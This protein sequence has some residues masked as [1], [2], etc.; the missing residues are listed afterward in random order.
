MP[1]D[2]APSLETA[3]AEFSDAWVAGEPLDPDDFCR[4]YP[5]FFPDL[6]RRI[7]E[8][9]YVVDGLDSA[10]G[11]MGDGGPETIPLAAGPSAD[12]VLGDFRI[13]R[14]IGRGGMGLVYEAEQVSLHRAVALKVLPPHLSFSDE[15]VLKFRR[16][17]E[18]GGRQSHP[19][20]VSVYAVGE[21]NGLHYIAQELVP[22]SRTL[23]DRLAELRG[24]GDLPVGYFRRSA[25]VLIA[26]AEA[27]GHAHDSG[28]IHRDVKPSNILLAGDDSPKLTDFGLAR[29]E[30]ALA[31]SRTGD[32]VGTPY[33]M[34]PEQVGGRKNIDF[35]TD[36]FSLGVT[37]YEML[38]LSL[39]FEGDTSQEVLRKILSHEPRDPRRL[40]H[41]VPRDLAVI[42][43]KA[44]EKR[45]DSRY[46]T[47][48]ELAD[49]L[50]RYVNGEPILARPAGAVTR[51]VKRIRRNPATSLAVGALFALLIALLTAVWL[52]GARKQAEEAE[53]EALRKKEGFRLAAE[54][55]IRVGQNAGQAVLLAIEA[56]KR[57]SAFV[58]RMVLIEAIRAC[59]VRKVI[60]HDGAVTAV[61]VRPGGAE[62]VTA[63]SLHSVQIWDI[64]KGEVLHNLVGHS[65]KVN[66][67]AYS[68]DGAF[69]LSASDDGTVRIWNASTG[70]EIH[71][72]AGHGDAVLSAAFS[73]DGRHV[74][75]ASRDM[76][77]MIW[78]RKSGERIATHEGY[79]WWVTA[80]VFLPDGKSVL[81]GSMDGTVRIR[82][83]AGKEDL[84]LDDRRSAV[85]SLSL[86]ADGSL[87][88][89]ASPDGEPRIY[90]VGAT[91]SLL[92][93]KHYAA[94]T[95]AAL[96]PDGMVAVTVSEDGNV[97]IWNAGTGEKLAILAGH[98]GSVGTLS[99]DAGSGTILTGSTDGTARVWDRHP[100][101]GTFLL[102]G[103]EGW[104][105]IALSSDGRRAARL[106]RDGMVFEIVDCESGAV[107]SCLDQEKPARRHADFSEDGECLLTA[108]SYNFPSLRRVSDGAELLLDGSRHEGDADQIEFLPG[109]EN[110]FLVGGGPYV[111]IRALPSGEIKVRI[112]L[113]NDICYA[114]ISGDGKRVLVLDVKGIVTVWDVSGVA[115]AEIL[116]ME[117]K[118]FSC[119]DLSRDGEKVAAVTAEG[120][121][122]LFDL[123]RQ[124]IPG[125]W[126]KLPAGVD[127]VRFSPD[128]RKIV[129][130]GCDNEAI[131]FTL[132]SGE[133]VARCRHNN[134]C[135]AVL[136]SPDGKHL[137]TREDKWNVILRNAENMEA[138]FPLPHREPVDRC[139]FCS[140]GSRVVTSTIDGS[141]SIWPVD[142][143]EFAKDG[144]S[145]DFILD[146]MEQF[147]LWDEV[148]QKVLADVESKFEN[149]ITTEAVKIA[150]K[151]EQKTEEERRAAFRVVSK[152]RDRPELLDR[153]SRDLLERPGAGGKEYERAL[154]LAEAVCRLAPGEE[155]Y[156]RT[157]GNALFRTGNFERS[158]ENLAPLGRTGEPDP[159]VSAMI[160]MALHHLG[161]PEE[162][163]I[164]LEKL[165]ILMTDARFAEDKRAVA[166][167]RE[168]EM[169]IGRPAAD[170]GVVPFRAVEFDG[171]SIEPFYYVCRESEGQWVLKLFEPAK[172][173]DSC[174]SLSLLPGEISNIAF[175][176]TDG[177]IC[178]FT[179]VGKCY[180]FVVQ[181][182]DEGGKTGGTGARILFETDEGSAGFIEW[183]PREPIAYFSMHEKLV[184][185]SGSAICSIDT[186][187]G[188]DHRPRR[189]LGCPGQVFEYFSVSPDGKRA[190]FSY[191][192][193]NSKGFETEVWSVS[194]CGAGR[195]V[196]DPRRLTCDG[197]ADDFKLHCRESGAIYWINRIRNIS[198]RISSMA[199]D[200]TGKRTVVDSESFL[201][202]RP[203]PFSLSAS[204][205][206]AYSIHQD[207]WYSVV[208]VDPDRRRFGIVLSSDVPI[209]F[210]RFVTGE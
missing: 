6:R 158:L 40:S 12:T 108:S 169:T 150:L 50:G 89:T 53:Q 196:R 163:G 70:E 118:R 49:D 113:E 127:F 137:I 75:T 160:A 138:L 189:I 54:A 42:C 110:F 157:L 60:V 174:F 17:A 38:T 104:E 148:E 202:L 123:G 176:P 69:L 201:L 198:T 167:L 120:V 161:R 159:P 46:A 210:P 34:S 59:H 64:R 114:R 27:L 84:W 74:A 179:I 204:G 182:L 14:E 57:D 107:L 143:V 4:N 125:K 136:F 165:R 152:Y 109:N 183:H 13:L 177:T 56:V 68:S 187:E 48:A 135:G 131:L 67:L 5:E 24:L 121:V 80:V 44:M 170:E 103:G 85:S 188:A 105:N 166:C 112:P 21:E 25:K 98:E 97:R 45:P 81:S 144:K 19:G 146:E 102:S 115:P 195:S 63:S 61:A 171:E 181:E 206:I 43:L 122:A 15:A 71:V 141:L 100:G 95:Q 10:A 124:R 154:D 209:L 119:A 1:V 58:T 129:L 47:M 184:N 130:A 149:L 191:F 88:I 91:K 203:G 111:N 51:V 134:A 90:K 33:Y 192:P 185:P 190:C 155:R 76:T 79:G 83:I 30:D 145:R 168:A 9:L 11:K 205:L 72:L 16:E 194:V 55:Q 208:V 41:R 31:L 94:V 96:S 199:A 37:L 173:D 162:A 36:V 7:D 8:F 175:H 132:S 62:G 52:D 32:L 23:G 101:L 172:K 22:G 86:S 133:E 156:R 26:V 92:E 3:I 186:R 39:P 164:A 66:C 142:P 153:Q 28:V 73:P 147:G 117:E 29:V 78:D 128:S 193:G 20:I 65:Q 106:S 126:E 87:V 140:G 207:D 178:Y 35:R 99:F 82:D 139:F 197:N 18:A 77:V 200:G 151:R 116:E 2:D 180:S 93:L